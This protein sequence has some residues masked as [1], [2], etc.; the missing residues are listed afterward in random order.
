MKKNILY[1]CKKNDFWSSKFLKHLKKKFIVEVIYSSKPGG[2]LKK[3]KKKNYDYIFCF[4]SYYILNKKLINKAKI[5]CINFHPGP[6]K[7]RGVGC[8]NYALYNKEKKYGV[9]AHFIDEKIDHGRIIKFQEFSITKK[10]NLESLLNKTHLNLFKLAKEISNTASKNYFNILK[11]VKKS[12]KYK[13]SKTIGT[14]KKLEKFYEIKF[15]SKKDVL[16]RKIKA[17]NY[18]QFKPYIVRCGYKFYFKS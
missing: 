12:K 16:K 13:W 5:A 8:I 2:K 11:Y 6:P 1:F 10:D 18:K 7:Y 14:R 17:L 9:T 4:I 15:N 3:T